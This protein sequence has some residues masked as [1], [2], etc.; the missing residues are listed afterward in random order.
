MLQTFEPPSAPCTLLGDAEALPRVDAPMAHALSHAYSRA[1]P[2]DVVLAG[3]PHRFAWRAVANP[4]VAGDTFR[5]RLGE[6]DGFVAIDRVTVSALLGERRS[7]RLPHELRCV[8]W[9]DALHA[10]ATAIEA[11]TRLPLQWLPDTTADTFDPR[12]A[13]GFDIDAS[14]AGG[15]SLGYVQFDDPAPLATWLPRWPV[16]PAAPDPAFDT[17]RVPVSF[18]IGRAQVPVAQLRGVCPGDIVGIGDWGSAGAAVRITAQVG[19]PRG[20]LLSGLVEGHR[21]TIQQTR[22][23]AMNREPAAATD[24]PDTG[25]SGA[26]AELPLDRLDALEVALRFEVGDLSL[27]LAELRAVRPGHIFQLPHSLSHS[28]VR[29]VAH[30]RVL[31]QGHLVAVGDQLGV[32]VAE[33]APGEL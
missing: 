32:R 22:D 1:A 28:P 7:E 2:V 15:R 29:I 26:A 31:G 33:F 5:F 14:A 25:A 4:A 3:R 8:L 30:G 13:A 6:H 24:V 20:V 11:T 27:S 18:V 21:I 16:A 23:L 17:L 9:A 10:V 19:G 12:R